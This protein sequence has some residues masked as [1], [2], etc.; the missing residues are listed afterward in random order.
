MVAIEPETAATR[1]INSTPERAGACAFCAV[2]AS[3][4]T[5]AQHVFAFL[6][7][8][9]AVDWNITRRYPLR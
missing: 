9:R 8:P 1:P 6:R 2:E 7:E 3:M 5:P 4:I